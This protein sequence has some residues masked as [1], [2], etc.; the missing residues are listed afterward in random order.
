MLVSHFPKCFPRGLK[1]CKILLGILG[2][3]NAEKVALDDIVW[4]KSIT[5]AAFYRPAKLERADLWK[6]L[7]ALPNAA[8]GR[9]L[10][11]S[12]TVSKIGPE[13]YQP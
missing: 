8:R 3:R 9:P 2:T 1:A 11:R 10:L 5:K 12:T 13:K 4:G 7:V 6:G